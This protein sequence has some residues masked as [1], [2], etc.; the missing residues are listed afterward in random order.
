MLS[1]VESGE[2][3]EGSSKEGR[4]IL[5]KRVINQEQ[6]LDMVPQAAGYNLISTNDVHAPKTKHYH[7]VKSEDFSPTS[8]SAIDENDLSYASTSLSQTTASESSSLSKTNTSYS[9]NAAASNTSPSRA[10]DTFESTDLQYYSDGGSNN[11]L[12]L[13]SCNGKL[14]RPSSASAANSG[15]MENLLITEDSLDASKPE[16]MVSLALQIVFPF[17]IAGCGMVAAGIVLDKVQVTQVFKGGTNPIWTSR[18]SVLYCALLSHFLMDMDK[19]CIN[20]ISRMSTTQKCKK[21][22]EVIG[23]Y[24]W[25]LNSITN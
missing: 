21:S 6:K 1:T 9:S 2:K 4:S 17:L 5:R 23:D 10:T 11:Q 15:S 25:A 20:G 22:Y 12:A 19:P 18:I 13:S 8:T 14:K 24:K 16:S 7:G 3:F